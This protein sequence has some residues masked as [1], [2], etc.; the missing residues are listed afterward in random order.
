M[1]QSPLFVDF[2]NI[3]VAHN[4][5]I[6]L[7]ALSVQVPD[8]EHV[9]ILGPNGSGKSTF[10]RTIIREHYPVYSESGSVFRIWGQD[11]WDVF[12]LRSHFGYV[13]QDLQV[14]FTR[15]IS[16]REVILSGFFS[17][18]G[19]FFHTITPE[20]VH[21]ADEILSFLEISHLADRS[22]S[23]MSTGEAR[24][25]LI[26]RALVHNPRV[27]ILDEPSNSLDLHALH[28]LRSTMRKVAGKTVIILVTHSLPDIIP[29]IKRVLLFKGGTIYQDGPKE[30]VLSDA[31]IR[32]VF[33]V[34][35]RILHDEGFYYTTGY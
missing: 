8:G 17:S 25:F 10:I 5:T 3:T 21:K 32:A 33:D 7:H 16:G 27:L 1:N 2:Q 6:L 34:P 23:D 19:L 9:A 30:E 4:T 20:M 12:T 31:S 22:F 35:V 13:S 15:N 14:T 28:M 24:R 26:G 11:T 29:E 18:I